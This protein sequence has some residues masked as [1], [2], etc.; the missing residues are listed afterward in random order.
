MTEPVEQIAASIVN[1]ATRARLRRLGINYVDYVQRQ[2]FE[3]VCMRQ[4]LAFAA[5]IPDGAE[6]SREIAARMALP[7]DYWA[8]R[9]VRQRFAAG[10]AEMAREAHVPDWVLKTALAFRR[11]RA[12]PR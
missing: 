3:R 2:R 9:S 7:A 4:E 6:L 8:A 1:E 12:R 5:R 11:F 10:E